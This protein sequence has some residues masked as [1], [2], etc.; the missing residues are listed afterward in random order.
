MG[1]SSLNTFDLTVLSLMSWYRKLHDVSAD[2]LADY[3]SGLLTVLIALNLRTSIDLI[4][5]ATGPVRSREQGDR[6]WDSPVLLFAVL[7]ILAVAIRS[8]IKRRGN[9]EDYLL[10]FEALEDR[11]KARAI[12]GTGLLVL[13]SVVF[14]V[15]SALRA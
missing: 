13:G 8:Y 11:R 15:W 10:R 12:V 2:R 5:D 14:F 4:D 6:I 9:A 1:R 3:S 7:L